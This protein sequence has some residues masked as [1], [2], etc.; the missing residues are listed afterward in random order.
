M[1]VMTSTASL[2][3]L[4]LTHDIA[5]LEALLPC[6]LV[7]L[8]SARPAGC[9]LYLSFLKCW[10]EMSLKGDPVMLD[11]SIFLQVLS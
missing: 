2:E 8:I 1:G 3:N 11:G 9:T 4:D 6:K 10:L 5:S 7:C